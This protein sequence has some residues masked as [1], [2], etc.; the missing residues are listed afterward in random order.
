MTPRQRLFACAS[1]VIMYAVLTTVRAI[2][3][4]SRT[5]NKIAF[6]A[7]F[8]VIGPI[9]WIL[10]AQLSSHVLQ[11]MLRAV[12]SGIPTLMSF[13]AACRRLSKQ[14]PCPAFG[15]LPILF[16]TPEE[17]CEL[18]ISFWACWPAL[19]LLKI[20]TERLPHLFPDSQSG[21]LLLPSE[22][23]RAL[24]IFTVW[25][26][27]WQGSLLFNYTVRSVFS[28]MNAGVCAAPMRLFTN[29]VSALPERPRCHSMVEVGMSLFRSRNAG[30]VVKIFI[31]LL[32]IGS[33]TITWTF[34]HTFRM[35]CDIVASMTVCFAAVDSAS[36]VHKRSIDFYLP[37]LSFWVLLQIW[38][39]MSQVPILGSGLSLVT[40]I[41]FSLF[42]LAGEPVL[43]WI[44]I[45]LAARAQSLPKAIASSF[46]SAVCLQSGPVRWNARTVAMTS[47]EKKSLQSRDEQRMST[48]CLQE[49]DC[50]KE[51]CAGSGCSAK[52]VD[53]QNLERTLFDVFVA[54]LARY[55]GISNVRAVLAVKAAL[56]PDPCAP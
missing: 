46:M 49:R 6:Q 8:I 48:D 1:V 42:F 21:D 12:L 47:S 53:W 52:V 56:T 29:L 51:K 43:Q 32:V 7:A 37:R 15:K 23:E 16:W 31:V 10:S 24:I 44:L 26:Q 30:N 11:L 22:L 36:I 19:M 54:P 17:W 20:A 28:A 27:F 45:P 55:L 9:L 39:T 3:K 41:A 25:L 40:P 14:D 34:Y 2:R 33:V 5:I 50:S 13:H 35:V 18:W 38:R 4:H